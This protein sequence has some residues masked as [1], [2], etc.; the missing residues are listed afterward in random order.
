MTVR[1][2][3]A[4]TVRRTPLW[5]SWTPVTPMRTPA[6][7]AAATQ[8]ASGRRIAERSARAAADGNGM[9]RGAS[10][11][12]SSR[13]RIFARCASSRADVNTSSA[14]PAAS[15]RSRS[16]GAVNSV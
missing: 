2:G 11:D 4:V 14:S 15:C 12:G 16:S 10:A 7:A 9:T 3:G 1:A 13:A 8:R 5:N 6:A